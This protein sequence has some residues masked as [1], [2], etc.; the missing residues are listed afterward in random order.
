MSRI[1]PNKE[2]IVRGMKLPVSK[3]AAVVA[4]VDVGSFLV[5]KGVAV[6]GFVVGKEVG[7]GGVCVGVWVGRKGRGVGEGETAAARTTKWRVIVCFWLFSSMYS[8]VR[9]CSPGVR[10]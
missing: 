10:S 8:M 9:V 2:R 4:G 5:G 3:L 7:V 6:G 1:E